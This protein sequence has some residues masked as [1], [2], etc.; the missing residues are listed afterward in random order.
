MPAVAAHYKF[1]QMVFEILEKPYKDIIKENREMFVLGLQGPDI[2]FFYKPYIKNSVSMVGS[3]I[4]DK[5]AI[6]FFGEKFFY[7]DDLENKRK[8]SY[9][10]GCICHYCLDKNCHPFVNKIAKTPIEHKKLEAELDGAVINK[11]KLLKTRYQYIPKEGIDFTVLSEIYSMVGKNELK[12]SVK[13]MRSYIKML[14]DPSI[15][16]LFENILLMKDKFSSL[17]IKDNKIY[18]KET[19]ELILLFENSIEEGKNLIEGFY[20]LSKKKI[21]NLDGFMSNFEGIIC[22]LT[23]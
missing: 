16:I 23:P 8:L 10:F 5:K 6:M 11:Y 17:S 21:N 1:G 4:H 20:D 12:K 13:D 14:E 15:V 3:Q 2:L 9:L 7:N 22:Q 18:E 19:R